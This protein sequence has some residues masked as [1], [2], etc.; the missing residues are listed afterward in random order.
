MPKLPFRDR[1]EAGRLLGVELGAEL[2]SRRLGPNPIV[3]ALARGGV[4]VGA[5]VAEAL[6]APLDVMV[7]R[8]LGVPWQPELAMGAIARDTRVLDYSLIAA[9]GISDR[10]LESVAAKETEE[11][12]RREAQYRQGR[13]E[14]ALEG[15]TVVLVD[16][17]L[18]TGSSMI[19]A[20]RH[21]R[22][23]QAKKLIVA[24]PVGSPEAC[25][26]LRSEADQCVCLAVQE[27]FHAVGEW[28]ADFSQVTDA[29][30]HAILKRIRSEVETS[31]LPETH[32]A[33]NPR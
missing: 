7:V 31:R 12:A 17:G 2:A 6:Q 24:V 15:R 30:V 1:S 19:A 3:M 16:D 21:A 27:P 14:P 23:A 26:R 28:Y 32:S 29:Q 10:E 4:P 33:S 5:Q 20:V 8:K 18:A 25:E 22:R 11:L 9:L 13:P